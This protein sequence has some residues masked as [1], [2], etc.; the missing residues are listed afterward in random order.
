[1]ATVTGEVT[2]STGT[3]SINYPEGTQVCFLVED[4]GEGA[5]AIPDGFIGPF[6]GGKKGCSVKIPQVRED[7]GVLPAIESGNLQV[8]GIGGKGE[9]IIVEEK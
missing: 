5:E 4:N 6:G 7:G 8:R 2:K 3:Y 1:M 9:V